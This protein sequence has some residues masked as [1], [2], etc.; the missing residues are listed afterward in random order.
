MDKLKKIGLY[1]LTYIVALVLGGLLAA[2]GNQF[3]SLRFLASTPEFGFDPF[4]LNVKVIVLT[5]GLHISISVGQIIMLIV[6]IFA[7]PKIVHTLL[8]S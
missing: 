2:L 7:A 3:D 4:T 5:L 1:I 6:A 8:G